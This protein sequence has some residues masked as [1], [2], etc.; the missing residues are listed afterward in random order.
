[1]FDELHVYLDGCAIVERWKLWDE[2]GMSTP[3]ELAAFLEIRRA[4]ISDK[5]VRVYLGHGDQASS[6]PDIVRIF[7]FSNHLGGSVIRDI[8]HPSIEQSG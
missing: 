2:G 7:D 8:E 3:K 6:S 4:E 1:M 5:E